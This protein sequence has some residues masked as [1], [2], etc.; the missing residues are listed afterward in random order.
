METAYDWITMAIF[1]GL[2]LVFLQ[3][4]TGEADPVDSIWH[5]LPPAIGC[6]VANYVGNDK[7]GVIS[8]AIGATGRH[9]L[10]ILI[11]VGV[12]AYIYYILRPFR[13]QSR[14]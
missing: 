7:A 14:P 6:M 10:A 5:Y 11:V 8:G 9:I 3:R 1:A 13:H 4:S 12:L 2:I